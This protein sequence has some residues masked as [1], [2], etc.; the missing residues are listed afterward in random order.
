MDVLLVEDEEL[1]R[2]ALAEELKDCGLAVQEA[3]NAED[4]L[5]M[6]GA[7]R[8]RVLVTDVNLGPG[9]DGIE[10]AEEA[11]RRWP[12]LR[13]VVMTGNPGN[14]DRLS[15]GLHR[16]ALTKP[17]AIGR[18]VARVRGLVAQT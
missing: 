17:F 14:L 6:N 16:A 8:A 12:G 15:P 11:R 13:V 2:E 1:I 3:G 18:L 10:L 9:M 7:D 5:A 4:A